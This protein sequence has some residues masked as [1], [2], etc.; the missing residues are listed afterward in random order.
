LAFRELFPRFEE[1][2]AERKRVRRRALWI[3]VGTVLIVAALLAPVWRFTDTLGPLDVFAF[4]VL[5][6]VF[7]GLAASITLASFRIDLREILL[8][9]TCELLRLRHTGRESTLPMYRFSEMRLLPQYDEA[10]FWTGVESAGPDIAF[11]AARTRLEQTY[12]DIDSGPSVETVWRGLLIA[13]PPPHRFRGRTAVMA[14]RGGF[15]RLL[16]GTPTFVEGHTTERIELGLGEL[17]AGL[18]ILTT[19]PA[20]AREILTERAMRRL[21]AL[22]RVFGVEQTSLAFAEDSVLLAIATD[23]NLFY[24]GSV[25]KFSR[26]IEI[27]EQLLAD[28][29]LLFDLAEGLRDA[30]GSPPPKRQG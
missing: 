14:R 15:T 17:E 22:M 2:E 11:T 24:T 6:A 18:E 5:P 7:G 13:V 1:V 23:A 3:A 12:S 20:E 8:P 21:A 9:K 28:F 29:A 30:V 10:S 26:R 25:E 19:D 16:K 4:G 27:F